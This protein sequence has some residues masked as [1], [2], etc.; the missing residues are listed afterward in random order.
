M[1]AD[2]LTKMNKNLLL[3]AVFSFMISSVFAQ[4]KSV[5]QL[6]FGGELGLPVGQIASVYGTVLGASAKLEIPVFKSTVFF[7]ITGG[8]SDYLVKLDYVNPVNAGIKTNV[9]PLTYIPFE[10]GAKYYFSK[11]GY[12][13]GDF[14]LSSNINRNVNDSKE[15]FIF[16]PVIGFSAP[17]NKHTATVDIALRYEDRVESGGPISQFALRL[18]YRFKLK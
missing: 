8:I 2:N 5:T 3:I 4:T 15:A 10:I 12:I 14:G 6:S 16:A 13:E 1:F 18:A 11:I 17:T 9:K 7:T